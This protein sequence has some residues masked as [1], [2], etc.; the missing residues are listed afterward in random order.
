VA[1]LGG[2][3]TFLYGLFGGR[4]A[5]RVWFWLLCP[6]QGASVHFVVCSIQRGPKPEGVV[7]LRA[8]ILG[9]FLSKTGS[10]FQ[11]L[12]GTTPKHG[13]CAPPGVAAG[14]PSPDNSNLLDFPSRFVSYRESTEIT[15][16]LSAVQLQLG[17][18]NWT[19][20]WDFRLAVTIVTT[21][22]KFRA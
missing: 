21:Q 8:G 5:D 4:A 17:N 10:G 1:A 14:I 20:E 2:R 18:T 9:H 12:S 16:G 13:S 19:A 22:L 15:L 3:G 6:K 11:T 7:L